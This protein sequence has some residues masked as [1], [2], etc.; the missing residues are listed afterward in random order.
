MST[1]IA[2]RSSLHITLNNSYKLIDVRDMI[3]LSYFSWKEHQAGKQYILADRI[4]RVSEGYFWDRQTNE[5]ALKGELILMWYFL[6]S[7]RKLV[8]SEKLARHLTIE[9]WLIA[10]WD[11]SVIIK[12]YTCYRLSSQALPA[13]LF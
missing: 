7:Q 12:M 4:D 13:E 8:V 6:C 3:H 10:R 1:E 5:I 9:Y 2:D 11:V